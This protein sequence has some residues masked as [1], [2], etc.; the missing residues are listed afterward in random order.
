MIFQETRTVIINRQLELTE[1]E[2]GMQEAIQACDDEVKR[3]QVSIENVDSDQANLQAKIEKKKTGLD[4]G[5]KRLL[6]LKKGYCWSLLQ[7]Y[8][9]HMLHMKALIGSTAQQW[10]A[11]TPCQKY[12]VRVR[13]LSPESIMVGQVCHW[14]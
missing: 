5:Q 8:D 11:E 14:L 6:T 4:R 7:T 12:V 9:D 3:N 2:A 13:H 1:V 10:L